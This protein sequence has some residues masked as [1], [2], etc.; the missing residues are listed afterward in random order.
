MADTLLGDIMR[1]R[2][3]TL[4]MD[5]TLG[6][7]LKA[8]QNYAEQHVLVLEDGLLAGAVAVN[9]IHANISPFAGNPASER[10]QDKA[11]TRKRVHQIMT[12]R[13]ESTTVETTAHDAAHL[14]VSG[15]LSVV[16]VVGSRGQLVGIVTAADL[17]AVAFNLTLPQEDSE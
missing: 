10:K 7:A 1:R 11:T 17:L 5:H 14:L 15:N 8:V 6:D 9:D 13:V 2:P 4:T 12:R 3:V 16:P